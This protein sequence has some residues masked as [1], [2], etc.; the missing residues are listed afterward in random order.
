MWRALSL[1]QVLAALF[2]VAI[3]T[4]VAGRLRRARRAAT[5]DT[6]PT[7]SDEEVTP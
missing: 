1:L 2:L 3:A 6:L 5:A 7:I 4:D